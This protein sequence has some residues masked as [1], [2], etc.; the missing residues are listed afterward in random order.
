MSIRVLV[1]GG[2]GYIGTILSH[3]LHEQKINYAVIDNLSNSSLRFSRK[4]LIF[5]KGNINNLS[6]LEKIYQEFKPTHIVHL[7]ASIDVNESEIKKKKYYNNNVLSTKKFI[8]FFI[9][10][11][12]KN[13]LFASTAAIYNYY[14]Q[15][16]KENYNQTPANYYGYTKLLIENFLLKKKIKNKLNVKIFRFFNVVGADKRLRAGNIS[17]KSKH[18]FNSLS[19]SIFLKNI[20]SINGKNYKTKD[21]TCIRDFVD[22]NDL[23]KIIIFFIKSKKNKYS[24]FNIGTNKGYSVLEVINYF[25]RILKCNIIYQYTKPRIGD[26]PILV[27][28]NK[29]LR[30]YYKYK[31]VDFNT[32]VRLH[33]L[34]YRKNYLKFI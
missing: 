34:F 21:G 26:A 18:L 33:Y 17:K 6:I 19:K 30:K 8:N 11:N 5:Y 2:T 3:Y 16:K 1:S 31:F 32:S 14:N 7:A 12:I 28:D 23:V 13:F 15:K 25:K 27:C 22:V 29:L 24:I 20:F 10:K 4:D 9:K